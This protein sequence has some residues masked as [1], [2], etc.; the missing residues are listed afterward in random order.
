M[1]QDLHQVSVLTPDVDRSSYFKYLYIFFFVYKD[2]GR[3]S[4][5]VRIM[6]KKIDSKSVKKIKAGSN[7]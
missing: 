7:I 4:V 5:S 1:I 6:A 2:L 3:L